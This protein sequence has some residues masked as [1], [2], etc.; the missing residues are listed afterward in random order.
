MPGS[1]PS[2][3]DTVTFRCRKPVSKPGDKPTCG[4]IA[5]P[6]EI[7]IRRFLLHGLPKGF[8]RIRHFGIPANGCRKKTVAAVPPVERREPQGDDSTGNDH[9]PQVVCPNCGKP[10][11]SVATLST[12]DPRRSDVPALVKSVIR[13]RGPP[14]SGRVT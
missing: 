9:A 1:C 6:V 5:L 7:F 13:L 11:E 14:R 2:T 3:A 12:G 8:H 10:S 4:T